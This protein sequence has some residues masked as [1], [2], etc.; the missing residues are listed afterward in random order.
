MRQCIEAP[1]VKVLANQFGR[2]GFI[3]LGLLNCALNRQH[4]GLRLA[5]PM[6]WISRG[7]VSRHG[8]HLGQSNCFT[9]VSRPEVDYGYR[10]VMPPAHLH[11]LF[12][13]TELE[14]IRVASAIARIPTIVLSGSSTTYPRER[15]T[16]W[17]TSGY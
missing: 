15:W 6:S 8:Q 16:S 3:T 7:V 4:F 12:I 1:H 11:R 10:A 5:G 9:R 2:L 13:K 17:Q 14:N